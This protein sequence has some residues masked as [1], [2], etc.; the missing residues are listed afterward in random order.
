[1][2]VLYA[3]KEAMVEGCSFDRHPRSPSIRYLGRYPPYTSCNL[4]LPHPRYEVSDPPDS[5]INGNW[6]YS[7]G[8]N[9]SPQTTGH[10]NHTYPLGRFYNYIGAPHRNTFMAPIGGGI[11]CVNIRDRR[12]KTQKFHIKNRAGCSMYAWPAVDIPTDGSIGFVNITPS[13]SGL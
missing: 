11:A 8:A 13:P 3:R 9:G 2:I 5:G 4:L 7:S 6:D 12:P 1:M 10:S